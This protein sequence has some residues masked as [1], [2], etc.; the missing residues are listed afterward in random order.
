MK[1]DFTEEMKNDLEKI[2][3]LLILCKNKSLAIEMNF[4][5]IYYYAV[6][7]LIDSLCPI[8][9]KRIKNNICPDCTKE[10]CSPYD[11]SGKIYEDNGLGDEDMKNDITYPHEI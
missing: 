11:P 5:G 8:C 3:K 7:Q 6:E 4:G 9:G 10:L 2:E 1:P